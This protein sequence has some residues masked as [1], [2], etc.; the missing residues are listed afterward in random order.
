MALSLSVGADRTGTGGYRM[1]R[2]RQRQKNHSKKSSAT[3]ARSHVQKLRYLTRTGKKPDPTNARAVSRAY[4]ELKRRETLERHYS[5]PATKKQ[6]DILKERGFHTSKKG[7]VIDG[8]RDS[9]REKIKGTKFSIL[10]SG[11]V[12][13]SIKQRRDYIYGFT[14]KE[15]KEFAKDPK[16]FIERVREKLRAEIP[17]LDKAKIQTRLQWGAFQGTKD[18]SPHYFTKVYFA[19]ASPEETRK[20][21]RRK[22]A[23]IDKLTGLHFVVHV[24]QKKKRRK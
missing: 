17:S 15:K 4:S 2:T 10:K 24:P 3:R 5:K 16:S 13:F 9:R 8:P 20:G 11:I 14:K 1:A 23:R 7:V 22:Q 19:E 6:R 21:R 12:K 18:F